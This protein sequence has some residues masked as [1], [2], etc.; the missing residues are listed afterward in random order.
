MGEAPD[1]E[2]LAELVARVAR[3]GAPDELPRRSAR[4]RVIALAVVGILVLVGVA[5]GIVWVAEPWDPEASVWQMRDDPPTLAE[6]DPPTLTEQVAAVPGMSTKQAARMVG[7]LQSN[8][9]KM[10]RL[11]DE[12]EE[13]TSARGFAAFATTGVDFSPRRREVAA[14]AWEIIYKYYCPEA[15]SS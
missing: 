4:R 14:A 10:A 2:P 9:H 3:G 12:C 1:D 15:A 6:Q 8:S 11:I 5:A 7:S 13:G